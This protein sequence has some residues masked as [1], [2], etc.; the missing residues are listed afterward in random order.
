VF[1]TV[2]KLNDPALVK[3]AA[4]LLEQENARLH[5][6]LQELVAEIARLKGNDGH[7]QLKL[8]IVKLQEQMATLRQDMFGV[9]SEKR[10]AKGETPAPRP[11]QTGHGPDSAPPRLPLRAQRW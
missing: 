10:K 11:P 6:R 5:T 9:S 4:L 7:K 8:E 3:Q 2:E 1:S